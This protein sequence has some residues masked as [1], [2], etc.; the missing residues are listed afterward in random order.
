M[1]SPDISQAEIDS[2]IEVLRS[3]DLSMGGKIL[4]F[5]EEMARISGTQYAVGVSSG[6][7]GLHL[8]V[9]VAGIGAGDLVVTTPFSFI[10]SSNCLLYEGA[11][12]IFVDV[13]D[14]TGNLDWLLVDEAVEALISGGKAAEKY[15]PRSMSKSKKGLDVVK[16]ILAVNVFL[17]AADFDQLIDI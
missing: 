15:L 11:V 9:I 8:S 3:S 1:S 10:A 7:A 5:E 13:E 14:Q 2:V 17:Q 12:P 16:G 6:T 4:A